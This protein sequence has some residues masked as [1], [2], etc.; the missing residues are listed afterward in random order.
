MPTRA[1]KVAGFKRAP[2]LFPDPAVPI[3]AYSGGPMGARGGFH[4]HT[5]E[6]WELC[7]LASGAANYQ[8]GAEK[9]QLQAGDLLVI[10]PDDPHVCLD[11]RG[12]RF[13]AIFRRSMLRETG[14]MVRCGRSVGL[15]VA[16][17]RIPTRTHVVPWRRTAVE[18]LL[19]RLQQESFGGQRAKLSMCAALLA[20]L[21]LELA[22][23]ESERRKMPAESPGGSAKKIV[24]RLAATV[25]ADLA[26]C[27]TLAELV[28]RSG[29]S[30]TQ[31]GVL[32][33]RATG[34]SPCQWISQERIHRACQ[35]LAHS[36]EA[37]VQ[38]GAEVGFGTRSQFYRV[39]RKVTGTTPERYRSAVLHEGHP[40]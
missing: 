1:A 18:Y 17:M 4:A 23:S 20:Q 11:W 13:V 34:L 19:D 29:Y 26:N 27:W 7:Y 33:R 14:L 31:L 8:L 10:G 37:V 28:K 15:E 35:L 3:M 16:G 36:E 2:I 32:F 25:R 9:L 5:D 39:F 38:V 30:S 24:E 21:L 6:D 40:L 22:R 12:E